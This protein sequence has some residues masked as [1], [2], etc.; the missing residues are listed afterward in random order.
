[1]MVYMTTLEFTASGCSNK[2]E[3]TSVAG[4]GYTDTAL[5]G[6]EDAI[7]KST[8][9]AFNWPKRLINNA[10][11]KTLGIPVYKR[12]YPKKGSV[13]GLKLILKV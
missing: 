12:K 4:L 11:A 3:I 1:M 6:S 10:I 2:T 8:F 9:C 13:F 7:V 5:T